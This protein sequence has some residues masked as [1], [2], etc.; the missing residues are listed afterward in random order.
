MKRIT[1]RLKNNIVVYMS[2]QTKTAIT[3][4]SFILIV[5]LGFA[6]HRLGPELSFSVFYLGPVFLAS[7]FGSCAIGLLVSFVAAIT[8]LTADL[9]SGQQYSLWFIPLWNSFV[10]LLFF[11]ITVYL[12]T[13]IRR[14]L[15]TEENL[16][17]T[18]S[19]TGLL[20]GRAFY[21]HVNDEIERA[22][23]YNHPFTL[24]Y[25]DLDNFKIINDTQG[26]N[27]GDK[28]LRTVAA[29]MKTNTRQSDI[30]GRLGGDEFACFF[31]ETD[32]GG[33]EGTVKNLF[34]SLVEAMN[35][36]NWSITFSMGVVTFQ[37]PLETVTEMIKYA[38]DVMYTVKKKGKN[39]Y[40]HKHYPDENKKNVNL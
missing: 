22:K 5:I 31:P 12:L 16:A 3:S 8:W 11:L 15:K 30:V 32:F 27:E 25:I 2:K 23:R 38:D 17:D 4:Y 39:D 29:V 35:R 10:R 34:P 6:D 33:G 26:H 21:E 14:K 1:L 24:A 9:V 7:W 40:I 28:V 37:K 36:N 20:N 18:D 13:V 19:L